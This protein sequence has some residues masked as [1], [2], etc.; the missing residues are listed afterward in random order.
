VSWESLSVHSIFQFDN[1][2]LLAAVDGTLISIGVDYD[3]PA[4]GQDA[5]GPSYAK[6]RSSADGRSWVDVGMVPGVIPTSLAAK[7]G[8]LVVLG[9]E[10]P[11]RKVRL[12]FSDDLGQTWHEADRPNGLPES[13]S[14][15]VANDNAFV[16]AG[17]EVAISSADGR[18]WAA[19]TS[20]PRILKSVVGLWPLPNGFLATH[21]ER[22]DGGEARDCRSIGGPP[23]PMPGEPD[24]VVSSPEVMESYPAP[25]ETCFM[26]PAG[27]GTSLSADGLEWHH[28]PDLPLMTND[29]PVSDSVVEAG[30]GA[31]LFTDPIQGARIWYSPL[32]D[33]TP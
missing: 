32:S 31:L 2:P 10:E 7:D 20:D 19:A 5:F 16:A 12:L 25:V 23:M 15:V 29:G 26:I 4:P 18:T 22:K 33:F 21:F 30:H 24:V 28:G 17:D 8:V 13:L 9:R 11:S 14:K 27:G 1:R 6:V 3:T